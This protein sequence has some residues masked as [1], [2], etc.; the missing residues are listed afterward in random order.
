MISLKKTALPIVFFLA[1]FSSKAQLLMKKTDVIEEYGDDYKTGTTDD[2]INYIFYEKELETAA[3]G[4]FIQERV[5]Y[6]LELDNGK[7]ICSMWEIFQPS[8]ET[9]S[10]VKHLKNQGLVEIGSMQ[11]KDYET[12]TLYDVK[13]DEGLCIVT[14]TYDEDK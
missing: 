14:A 4:K 5:I 7:K 3:S 9:N 1:A 6:L 11:W 12:N 2:G 10:V 13:V 8:S